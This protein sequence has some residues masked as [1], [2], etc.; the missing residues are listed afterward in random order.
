LV[1]VLFVCT[2]NMCRSPMAAALFERRLGDEALAVTEPVRTTSAGLLPGGHPSP[3]EV[4]A[5][6]ADFDVDLSE[7]RSA[8]VT[9][10]VVGNAD[11][12]LGLARRHA[13][14]VVLLDPGAWGRTFTVKE[15]VR[16]GESAGP[17]RPEEPVA[18]WLGRLHRG[19]TRNDLVG[20]FT[21]DDV[22]DP[23]GGPMSAYRATARELAGLVDEVAALLWAP[24]PIGDRPR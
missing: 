19:R 10:E 13:R 22:A 5:A 6:M 15:F 1:Q 17:R 12:V 16:R 21:A 11:V 8:Q 20:S 14:E 9:S 4:V 7:H 23:L 18:A 2:A 24:R 3:A